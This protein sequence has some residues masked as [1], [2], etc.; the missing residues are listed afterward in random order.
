MDFVI[1]LVLPKY[2]NCS[3]TIIR[4]STTGYMHFLQ[5]AALNAGSL[6]ART[7]ATTGF[8]LTATAFDAHV[9]WGHAL[10]L[11]C[12]GPQQ[13]EFSSF[14]E[15]LHGLTNSKWVYSARLAAWD[16]EYLIDLSTMNLK[17]ER[18]RTYDRLEVV[19]EASHLDY[20]PI[21]FGEI[22]DYLW[23]GSI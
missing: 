16:H 3:D 6:T 23:S 1:S 11:A 19:T 13:W 15:E 5:V 10:Y 22:L 14:N 17:A 18:W 9:S 7:V 21:K 12:I 4:K 2:G 20:Y 8:S